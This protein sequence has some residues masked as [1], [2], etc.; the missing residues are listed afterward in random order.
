MA[1]L[2]IISETAS[3]APKRLACRRTN[4]L[5]MPASGASITRL[6]ISTSPIVHGSCSERIASEGRDALARGDEQ[7]VPARKVDS[8]GRCNTIV[9]VSRDRGSGWVAGQDRRGG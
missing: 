6:G 3:P 1:K 7:I 2:E 8:S 9:F 5:P 4:Q